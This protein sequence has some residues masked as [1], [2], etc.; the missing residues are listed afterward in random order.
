VTQGQC[1]KTLA[2]SLYEDN[3]LNAAEETTH[4]A[5]DLLSEKGNQYLVCTFHR[6]IQRRVLAISRQPL[7][8]HPLLAGTTSCLGLILPWRS[9]LSRRAGL[10]M[11]KLTLGMP[12]CTWSMTHMDWVVRWSCRL[13]CTTDSAGLKKQ[14]SRFCA[15]LMCM[16]SS[17]INNPIA[18]YFY[19]ELLETVPLPTSTNF[20]LS[21]IGLHRPT[22]ISRNLI[23]F[24]RGLWQTMV[25]FH[26]QGFWAD[27]LLPVTPFAA[28]FG[29]AVIAARVV[30]SRT[31]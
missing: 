1:L 13:G 7:G 31:R 18:L 19:G 12:S 14:G 6:A 24:G 8:L 28:M 10:V 29:V 9:F 17:G 25:G 16:R 3:Q 22:D 30:L 2:Q 27:T 20:I 4:H 15:L 23:F 11:H 21:G 26:L 5:I